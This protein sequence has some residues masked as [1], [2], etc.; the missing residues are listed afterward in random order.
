MKNTRPNW[1]KIAIY[2]LFYA[3]GIT[4]IDYAFSGAEGI[5]IKRIIGIPILAIGLLY[6]VNKER[7]LIKEE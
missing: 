5:D 2:F 1:Q 6:I 4:A 3:A 7:F